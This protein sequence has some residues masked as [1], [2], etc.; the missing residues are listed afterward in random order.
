MKIKLLLAVYIF[1]SLCYKVSA[2]A[3]MHEAAEDS[4]GS[5]LDGIIGLL[6]FIGLGVLIE[7]L[8]G[9]EK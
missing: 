3:Y 6:L 8:W 2:Q 5:P 9:G 4:D 1:Y 7:K